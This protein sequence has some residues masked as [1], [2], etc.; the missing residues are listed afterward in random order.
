M[1]FRRRTW[2]SWECFRVTNPFQAPVLLSSWVCSVEQTQSLGKAPEWHQKLHPQP[3]T[4]PYKPIY[5]YGYGKTPLVWQW[6]PTLVWYPHFRIQI[7]PTSNPILYSETLFLCQ[8]HHFA[9]TT[10]TSEG[11]KEVLGNR[12]GLHRAVGAHT[13]KAG[14]KA[15]C[16]TNS[17]SYF[18]KVIS[19]AQKTDPESLLLD[20]EL[21]PNCALLVSSGLDV[22]S[23][24]KKRVSAAAAALLFAREVIEF[25]CKW[26]KLGIK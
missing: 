15:K 3:P 23:S 14:E 18:I 21:F 1:S 26:R 10:T 20:F 16:D 7:C 8:L 2:S 19:F 12:P 5:Y 17:S 22:D 6:L 13:N 4:L 25:C 24:K 9:S 11:K